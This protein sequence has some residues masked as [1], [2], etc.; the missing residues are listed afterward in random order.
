VNQQSQQRMTKHEAA[1]R[2]AQL[3]EKS[4]A[5]KGLSE[6]KRNA[7]VRQGV[8]YVD[9]VIASRGNRAK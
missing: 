2:L 9:R 7:R 8:E 3:I 1:R 6:D 4:M 5:R